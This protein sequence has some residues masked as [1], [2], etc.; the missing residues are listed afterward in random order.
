MYEAKILLSGIFVLLPE[1]NKRKDK[2]G[3][4]EFLPFLF[5]LQLDVFRLT[6]KIYFAKT[7]DFLFIL[8]YNKC[9]VKEREKTL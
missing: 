8:C 2:K 5:Y 6:L 3:R 9:T 7:I 4:T 1:M